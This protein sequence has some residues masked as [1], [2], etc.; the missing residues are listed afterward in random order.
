MISHGSFAA[1]AMP[2]IKRQTH[3][4]IDN[5]RERRELIGADNMQRNSRPATCRSGVGPTLAKRRTLEHLQDRQ[6][7][8]PLN[9]GHA[10]AFAVCLADA[11]V[12]LAGSC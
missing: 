9:V 4:R 10:E 7:L 3:A 6:S 11:K 1:R 5:L 8:R 2:A 12:Y